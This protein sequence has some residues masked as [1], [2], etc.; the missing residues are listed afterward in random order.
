MMFREELAFKIN[1]FPSH[2]FS[3]QL[4]VQKMEI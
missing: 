3:L 1:S 4:Y 2:F